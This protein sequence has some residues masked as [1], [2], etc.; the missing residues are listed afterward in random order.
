M[1]KG[2]T[3]LLGNPILNRVKKGIVIILIMAIAGYF[4][5]GCKAAGCNGSAKMIGFGTA[6]KTV[7]KN[8]R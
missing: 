8:N 1:N 2:T 3:Q 7:I 5:A 4:L 6:T